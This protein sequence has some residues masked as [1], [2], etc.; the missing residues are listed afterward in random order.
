MVGGQIAKV[1][2][3]VLACLLAQDKPRKAHDKTDQAVSRAIAFLI[4]QQDKDGAIQDRALGAT[5]ATA[6]T[7]LAV[8][9]MAAVGHQPTDDTKEG[10]AMRRALQF[11]LRP[12]RQDE[13]G[14]FGAVDG[15]RMYGHGMATLML[16][17]MLGM[18]VDTQMDKVLRERAGKAVQ[19]LLRSQAVA[20]DA[21][22]AGGWRYLPDAADS[23]LSITVWAVMA[24]RSAK[25]AGLDVPKRAIDQ[26]VAY[27]RRC[28][29]SKRGPDGRP[30][31]PRAG[32]VYHHS[33]GPEFAMGAAGLLALQV[34]GAYDVP[35]VKGAAEWLRG[36][37]LRYDTKWFFYGTYYYAQGMFQAGDD[38]AAQAR[39]VVEGLLLPRQEGDGSWKGAYERENGAG[40]VYT[41]SLGVLAL[42]VKYHYL[43]I[44]QR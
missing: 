32:F 26:A 44:Y 19:L 4:A 13:Q 25:N 2:L 29:A 10:T 39:K 31:E 21:V 5:S 43:P 37:E 15:S 9:A 3:M 1:S 34:C 7:S 18:G 41:T 8:M 22:Q 40:R 30:L 12:D 14:Y 35:E 11:V 17:E 28:Y 42:A 20:K 38:Y 24:L 33:R 27:I 6:M 23:D 16:C 36:I